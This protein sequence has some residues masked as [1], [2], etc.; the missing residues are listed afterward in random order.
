MKICTPL[1]VNHSDIRTY[2]SIAESYNSPYFPNFAVWTYPTSYYVDDGVRVIDDP[3]YPG[4]E[5]DPSLGHKMF[6]CRID[7][8][9]SIG[10]R[11]YTDHGH[12]DPY[13][14]QPLYGTSGWRMFDR[15]IH[16]FDDDPNG[17]IE[18]KLQPDAAT[19]P[20]AISDIAFLNL[21]AETVRVKIDDPVEGV[22]YDETKNTLELEHIMDFYEWFFEPPAYKFSEVFENL[23]VY[24]DAE[25]TIQIENSEGAEVRIGQ[26]VPASAT[27]KG[28]TSYPTSLSIGNYSKKVA[29]ETGGPHTQEKAGFYILEGLQTNITTFDV[30]SSTEY[31]SQI[32]RIVAE[33]ASD[34][35][36]YIGSGTFM[37]PSGPIDT[38]ESAV[39]FGFMKNFS[40][41]HKNTEWSNWKLTIEELN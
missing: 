38:R 10:N 30:M 9:S 32:R 40:F 1:L 39:I 5:D 2:C 12:G 25:I 35:T 21:T 18:V 36:L 24:Y 16:T 22:V 28:E 20:I 34:L 15:R 11:P 4:W 41:T 33:R 19:D 37:A 29:A 6:R 27:R 31:A 13:H 3:L 14:W 26:I 23:P 7:H 8:T 17:S